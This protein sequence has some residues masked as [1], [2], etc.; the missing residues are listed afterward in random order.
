MNER[1]AMATY[2][3]TTENRCVAIFDVIVFKLMT[4]AKCEWKQRITVVPNIPN[5]SLH[6]NNNNNIIMSFVCWICIRMRY[7]YRWPKIESECE[8]LFSVNRHRNPHAIENQKWT[9]DKKCTV[10]FPFHSGE[11]THSLSRFHSP[12]R[13]E[14]AFHFIISA[15]T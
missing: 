9:D 15:L 1:P 2:N 8:I 13:R 3:G 4:N 11:G 6:I 7:T 5:M 12:L 14:F 10:Y